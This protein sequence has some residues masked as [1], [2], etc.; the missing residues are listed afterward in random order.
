MFA[1]LG[2]Q[3]THPTPLEAMQRLRIL[4][5]GQSCQVVV[6]NPSVELEPDEDREIS[7]AEIAE[8]LAR[9]KFLD[10]DTIVS[11]DVTSDTVLPVNDEQ[12]AHLQTLE[13][14]EAVTTMP[15]QEEIDEKSKSNS[16]QVI[17]L[18]YTDLR[19]AQI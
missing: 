9:Q 15:T 19:A 18:G 13:D 2:G 1:G 3:N 14:I 8:H 12:I 6:Q 5:L 4:L 17:I 10:D 16:F 11:Q 7:P